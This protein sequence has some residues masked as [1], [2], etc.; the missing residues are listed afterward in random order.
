LVGRDPILV[1]IE[2]AFI[3]V[4]CISKEEHILKV[5][6]VRTAGPKHAEQ[7]A[8]PH[9][10]LDTSREFPVHLSYIDDLDAKPFSSVLVSQALC[11]RNKFRGTVND[12]VH[13]R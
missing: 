4:G 11:S 8:K 5:G 3:V 12:V 6:R 2:H 10:V 13:C 9:D 1:G 7:V